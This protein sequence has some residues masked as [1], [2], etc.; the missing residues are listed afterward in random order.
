MNHVRKTRTHKPTSTHSQQTLCFH[1]QNFL[2]ANQKQHS[3]PKQSIKVI[4]K[5]KNNINNNNERK[6]FRNS[7]CETAV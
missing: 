5:Y 7:V 3:G 2:F 6:K 1:F 4:L